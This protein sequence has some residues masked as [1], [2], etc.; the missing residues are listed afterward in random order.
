MEFLTGLGEFATAKGID[1]HIAPCPAKEETAAYRRLSSTRQVDGVF[2]SSPVSKDPRIELLRDISI[3]FIVHGRSEGVTTRYSFLD[4]D[5][6]SAFRDATKLLLELG[7]RRLGLINGERSATFAEHREIGMIKAL[8]DA[9]L[10]QDP[11]LVKWAPMSEEHGYRSTIS[12]LDSAEPPTALLCSSIIVALGAI[13]ALGDRGV[14]VG[15]G[16]SVI[17]HDDVFAYLRPENFRVPLTCTRSSIRK[18]GY[19]I[20]ERLTALIDGIEEPGLGEIWPVELIVRNS[21][22]RPFVKG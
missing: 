22:A 4:I 8:E 2:V 10:G 5:N 14:E 21:T 9:G 6:I 20:A 3:P 7:H 12:L 17:A 11:S 18:A 15:K 13:R 16:M 1:I 19:R